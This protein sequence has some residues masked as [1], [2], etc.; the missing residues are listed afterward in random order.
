MQKSVEDEKT[1]GGSSV[2]LE[3]M[4]V[5]LSP[6]RSS[7]SNPVRGTEKRGAQQRGA[8]QRA[9]NS[10]AGSEAQRRAGWRAQ[11]A[12][13]RAK[14]KTRPERRYLRPSERHPPEEAPEML[15]LCAAILGHSS[16]G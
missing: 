6:R 14:I 2:A 13:Q 4:G 3:E 16:G 12:G 7:S 8:Q 11:G 9:H 1:W 10:G 15:S 5:A